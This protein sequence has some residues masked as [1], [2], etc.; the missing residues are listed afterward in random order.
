[1]PISNLDGRERNGRK[2]K[3]AAT[4]LRI[5]WESSGEMEQHP[6]RSSGLG[7]TPRLLWVSVTHICWTSFFD[8]DAPPKLFS[9][10]QCL[11]Q[12]GML[13]RDGSRKFQT[14]YRGMAK[15]YWKKKFR[16]A[17]DGQ[18]SRT[19]V[20]QHLRDMVAQSQATGP[21]ECQTIPLYL[22]QWQIEPTLKVN[23]WA[24]PAGRD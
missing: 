4:K 15:Y 17:L 22:A 23:T 19:W 11:T 7:V 6:R 24:S 13:E 9:E 20:T 14:R 16:K 21:E 18:G 10:S 1:M 12:R 8:H 3:A 2:I 5:V